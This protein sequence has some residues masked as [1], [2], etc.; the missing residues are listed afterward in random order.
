[1]KSIP[2]MLL[3]FAV[4][5]FPFTAQRALAQQAQSNPDFSNVNDILQ[6]NRTLFQITDLQVSVSGF[7]KGVVS[8]RLAT[9]NSSVTKT[10]LVLTG[11]GSFP[12]K[13]FSGW[14]F[15]KQQ[16]TT[17]TETN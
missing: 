12:F 15:N 14:M 3:V 4:T 16:A 8:Y 6:G 2:T 1:M 10:S 17:E 11:L 5:V 7:N 9:S 13:S